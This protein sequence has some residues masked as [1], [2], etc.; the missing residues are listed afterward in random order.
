MDQNERPW[1]HLASVRP[2]CSKRF[3]PHTIG[4]HAA[5]CPDCEQKELEYQESSW[6]AN[7]WDRWDEQLIEDFDR[8]L[9]RLGKVLAILLTGVFVAAASRL[10]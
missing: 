9:G 8:W 1:H 7:Q 4:L 3:T 6:E 2:D 10:F 5:P